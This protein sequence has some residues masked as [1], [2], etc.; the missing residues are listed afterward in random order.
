MGG[1]RDRNL[2]FT[3]CKNG[4]INSQKWPKTIVNHQSHFSTYVFGDWEVKNA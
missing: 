4:A 1:D 3:W 2:S